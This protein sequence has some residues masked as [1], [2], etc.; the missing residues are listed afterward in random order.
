M[1]LVAILL[2]T[3]YALALWQPVGEHKESIKGQ[4]N[5]SHHPAPV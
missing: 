2:A 1:T 4:V 3:A 5:Y